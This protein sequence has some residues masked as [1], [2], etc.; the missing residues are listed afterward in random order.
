MS[1]KNGVD[2]FWIFGAPLG[3]IALAFTFGARLA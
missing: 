1:M 2:L 3:M